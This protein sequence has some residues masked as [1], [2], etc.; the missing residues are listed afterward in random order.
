M[1]GLSPPP[2]FRLVVSAGLFGAFLMAQGRRDGL[3]LVE[4]SPAGALRSFFAVAL[5]LPGFLALRFLT[6]WTTPP[7]TELLLRP[8]AAEMIGY[9]LAWAS[10]ALCSQALAETWGRNALWPRFIAA[11]NWSNVVQYLVLLALALPSGLNLPLWIEQGLA[12]GGIGYA[13][14]F[15]WFV[16]RLA[17]SVDGGRAAALVA[18]DL[19]IGLFVGGIA[20]SLSTG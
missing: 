4:D 5:C 20:Q 18:L 17:L 11:F 13:L 10:F 19:I 1:P 9:V 12:L 3:V 14:W 8:L 6:W 2:S 15:E 7:E 16:V